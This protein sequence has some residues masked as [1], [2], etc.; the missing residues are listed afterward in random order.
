MAT[1][2][3]ATY[4]T[5]SGPV[6]GADLTAGQFKFV[7]WSS[8]AIV[9]AAAGNDA[10]GVLLNKPNTGEVCEIQIGGIV[11]VQ[12]DVALATIGTKVMSSADGQ[13]AVATSTNHVL[14]RTFSTA[15]A[16]GE[17]VEVL[18]TA[19]SILA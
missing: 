2:Q 4:N 12:A 1:Q 18:L 6:A 14:G 15:S 7:K 9:L 8:G 17:Y 13:A 19:P 10:I 3:L 5:I 16:A 11:K